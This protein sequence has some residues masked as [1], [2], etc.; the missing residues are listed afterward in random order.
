M[1]AAG[2]HASCQRAISVITQQGD[3]LVPAGASVATSC[4]DVGT[5][6]TADGSRGVGAVTRITPQDDVRSGSEV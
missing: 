5:S 1:K 4:V 3:D 2:A 6:L